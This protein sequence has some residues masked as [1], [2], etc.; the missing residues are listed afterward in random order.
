[1]SSSA[2]GGDWG[3]P[4]KIGWRCE[5]YFPKSFPILD[6]ILWLS[7]PYLWPDQTFDTLSKTWP[8]NQPCFRPALYLVPSSRPM[9]YLFSSIASSYP[10]ERKM[11]SRNTPSP[12]YH[13]WPD[14]VNPRNISEARHCCQSL[15][16]THVYTTML[17]SE[18]F[19]FFRTIR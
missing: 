11:I 3:T 9:F 1:M 13:T 12:G 15:H 17:L 4:G 10:I 18:L 14:L 19:Y 8:L 16:R 5:A 7:L 2:P 6:Q